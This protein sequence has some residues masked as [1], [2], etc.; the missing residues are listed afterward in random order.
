[1]PT[2][3][4]EVL[5]MTPAL[6]RL[7]PA[8][9]LACLASAGRA[10]DWPQWMGPDRDDVWREKGI[11][12]KFPKEGPKV[13][14]RA[15]VAWGYAGPAVADSRVY[16]MDYLT[17]ADV[18]K[19]N[20]ANIWKPSKIEGKERV[21]CLDAK[22][23]EVLWKHEYDCPYV[24]SFP[25]GP[26]CTPT[27]HGGKVYTLGAEGNLF[28]LDAFKG[29]VIW[30]RDFKKD[31]GAKTPPWGFASHPLVDG[32]RIFCV[33]GGKGS[34]AVAFDKDTG[35][36]LWKSLSVEDPVLDAGAPV[37]GY[38]PP[39]LIDAGG[40]TQ[41]VIWKAESINGLDPETGKTYWSVPLSPGN[42]MAIATPRRLG[43]YLFVTGPAAAL[44][45]KLNANK[46]GVKEVW[47]GKLHS[48][49]VT[50]FLEDGM[51]YGVDQQGKLCGVKLDTGERSWQTSEPVSGKTA[52]PTGTAFLVKNGDRF[53]IFNEKGELVIAML[54]PKGYEEIDRCKVL[55]PTNTANGREVLWSHPAF[56]NKCLFARND[57]EILC[58]SLAAE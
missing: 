22:S 13:L 53:F 25:G 2:R 4:L 32:Q 55:A 36:E 56:A 52:L 11:L 54:T 30:A 44:L 37:Q 26:R 12:A 24:I 40:K 50:P 34:V 42:G 48:V 43:D 14:W 58:A 35:Q 6:R 21:R 5:S 19:L 33:V 7:L 29:S 23:G 41:L 46:P 10:D 57:K 1:M 15:S 16:V 51:I 8:L 3:F 20:N 45:L 27:V 39:T 38:C 9:A 47:R 17:E 28:C 18:L 49:N 31:Y